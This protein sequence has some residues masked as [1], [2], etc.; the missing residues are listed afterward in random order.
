MLYLG[1][2]NPMTYSVFFFE[3][4]AL[5]LLPFC[6]TGFYCSVPFSYGDRV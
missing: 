2:N 1:L 3:G 5:V 4:C 6:F